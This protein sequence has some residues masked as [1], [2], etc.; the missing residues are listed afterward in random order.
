[1]EDNTE[2]QKDIKQKVEECALVSVWYLSCLQNIFINVYGKK[3]RK[4][5]GA[6]LGEVREVLLSCGNWS[7]PF[8]SPT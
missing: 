1:M 8:I 4:G 2:I 5:Q 6:L 7:H 3:D